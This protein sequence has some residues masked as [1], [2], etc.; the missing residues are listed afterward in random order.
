MTHHLPPG[1]QDPMEFG[2]KGRR[3]GG[4]GGGR[5]LL[6]HGHCER[7]LISLG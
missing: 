2:E 6:C 5:G 7:F 1:R 3:F 4:G